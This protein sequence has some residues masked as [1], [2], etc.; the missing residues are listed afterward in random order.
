MPRVPDESIARLKRSMG[1]PNP[2]QPIKIEGADYQAVPDSQHEIK[3]LKEAL[4]HKTRLC[5][6]IE[7]QKGRLT[8]EIHNL[9]WELSER[10][11]ENEALIREKRVTGKKIQDLQMQLDMCQSIALLKQMQEKTQRTAEILS[12]TLAQERPHKRPRNEPV[13]IE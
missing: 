8:T 12:A 11:N 9:E 6:R 1:L 13:L 10:N 2:E 7:D 3:T 4:A 5:D